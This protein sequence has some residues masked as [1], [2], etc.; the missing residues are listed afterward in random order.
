[1]H[2]CRCFCAFSCPVGTRTHARMCVCQIGSDRGATCIDR[3]FE[4]FLCSLRVDGYLNFF[5]EMKQDPKLWNQ[6]MYKFEL[7]KT[8][9]DGSRDMR[10]ELLM[11]NIVYCLCNLIIIIEVGPW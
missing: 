7:S 1:V 10:I 2:V 11:T 9:F 6:L 8:S 5:K 3:A 4:N